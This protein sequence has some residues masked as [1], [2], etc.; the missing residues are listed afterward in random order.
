MKDAGAGYPST[1]ALLSQQVIA[2][3]TLKLLTAN[4]Y[5]LHN[6]EAQLVCSAAANIFLVSPVI[7]QCMDRPL[8]LA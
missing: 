8:D 2:E 6:L 4:M 1:E 7:P 5:S 3:G